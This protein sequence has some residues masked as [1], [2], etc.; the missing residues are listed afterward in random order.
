M[1]SSCPVAANQRRSTL[2]IARLS[3][4]SAADHNSKRVSVPQAIKKH[5]TQL[6]SDIAAKTHSLLVDAD[7]NDEDDDIVDCGRISVSRSGSFRSTTYVYNVDP[8]GAD[9]YISIKTVVSTRITTKKLDVKPL[10]SAIDCVPTFS[11]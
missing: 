11:N 1:L 4:L 9:M 6:D 8:W 2:S 3:C 10:E 5:V 7:A